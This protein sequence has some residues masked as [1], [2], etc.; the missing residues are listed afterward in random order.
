MNFQVLFVG[1]HFL[2]EVQCVCVSYFILDFSFSAVCLHCFI[3]L[4]GFFH[5]PSSLEGPKFPSLILFVSSLLSEDNFASNQ[6]KSLLGF[7]LCYFLFMMT[8]CC[9]AHSFLG[10]VPRIECRRLAIYRQF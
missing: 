9:V 3:F 6:S 8:V 7:L 2:L 4:M 1:N 5:F 10:L